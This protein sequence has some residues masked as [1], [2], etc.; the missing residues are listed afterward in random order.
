MPETYLG[1]LKKELI[2]HIELSQQEAGCLV[3]EVTQDALNTHRFNVYEEFVSPEAFRFHQ[4]R[5]TD[6]RW[7]SISS[8]LEKHY[9]TTGIN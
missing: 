2:N 7:G 3:F 8:K 6:T 4:Q 1:A 9:T 5:L